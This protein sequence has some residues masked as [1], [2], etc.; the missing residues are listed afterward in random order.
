[1]ENNPVKFEDAYNFAQYLVYR[2]IPALKAQNQF[3]LA[4]DFRDAASTIE[5]MYHYINT[6]RE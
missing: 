5:R 4:D 2:L 1:M 6:H 3:D